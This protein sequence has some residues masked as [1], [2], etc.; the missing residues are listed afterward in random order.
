VAV[1][2]VTVAQF[3]LFIQNG[4]YTRERLWTKAGWQW[5]QKKQRT[6]PDDYDSAF[7]TPNHPRVGVTWYEAV[8]F[9][10]WLNVTFRPE[11][12]KLLGGWEVRLP[13][14]GEWERAARHTDGRDFPWDPKEKAEAAS[15]CNCA[16]TNIGHTSAVG[17]FPSGHAVCGAADMAGNVWEWCLTKGRED[18]KNYEKLADQG[19]EGDSA[20]VLRGGSWNSPAVNARCA[21]RFG[22]Y[23]GNR[24]N[25]VGFRVVASSFFALNSDSSEL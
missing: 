19:Q 4:G 11:D 14:E 21:Y 1:Y 8:A 20:R 6:R 13:S 15:R 9:C 16:E 18:Y 23:P 3:E 10:K 2:P 22:F 24:Y 25:S 12:L 7:Q 5:R 17:M